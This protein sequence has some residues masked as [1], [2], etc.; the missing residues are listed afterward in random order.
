MG[1]ARQNQLLWKLSLIESISSI[2]Q[3]I[4]LEQTCVRTKH[5]LCLNQ[6]SSTFIRS[7]SDQNKRQLVAENF[8]IFQISMHRWFIHFWYLPYRDKFSRGLNFARITFREDLISQMANFIFREDKIS[9]I[10]PDKKFSWYEFC[11]LLISRGFIFANS[12]IR[13]LRGFNFANFSHS[14]N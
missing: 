7:W 2:I 11:I 14:R 9:R 6:T 10:C 13:I 5:V 12:K 4:Y 1:T 3:R 8:S